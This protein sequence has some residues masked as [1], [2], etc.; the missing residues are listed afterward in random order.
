ML[1]G[2][3]IPWMRGKV[4]WCRT[5]KEAG[6]PWILKSQQTATSNIMKVLKLWKMLEQCGFSLFS[7]AQHGTRDGLFFPVPSLVGGR[8]LYLGSL[9]MILMFGSGAGADEGSKA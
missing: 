4:R 9:I 6:R 7:Y 8:A 2:A 5:C 3:V 1:A